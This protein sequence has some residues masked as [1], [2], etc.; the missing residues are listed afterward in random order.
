[1]EGKKKQLSIHAFMKSFVRRSSSGPDQEVSAKKSWWGK[2]AKKCHGDE[3]VPAKQTRHDEEEPA[4]KCRSDDEERDGEIPAKKSL[5]EEE[6]T[7]KK[8]RRD[9]EVLAKKSRRDGEFSAKKS[10]GDEEE[11]VDSRLPSDG[12]ED[13]FSLWEQGSH[14][15]SNLKTLKALTEPYQPRTGFKFPA[16]C[17]EEGKTK[18]RSFQASWFGKCSWLHY[19]VETDAAFCFTCMAA[20]ARKQILSDNIDPAFVTQGYRDWKHA[21]ERGDPEKFLKN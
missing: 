20:L 2:P 14:A 1:M 16:A 17:E 6:E 8:S 19:D 11:L 4:K 21:L 12:E 7:T 9:G 15:R 13:T 18:K 10:R 3:D 5:R